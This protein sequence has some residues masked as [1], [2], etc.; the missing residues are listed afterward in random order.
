MSRHTDDDDARPTPATGP[1]RI[2][3]GVPW[4][5]AG[6]R[7]PV[8]LLALTATVAAFWF[9]A[10]VPGTIAG[11][12]LVL[13]YLFVPPVTVFAAG[14][15]AATALLPPG[16]PVGLVAIPV[17]PLVVLLLTTPTGSTGRTGP[18]GPGRLRPGV[19]LVATALALLGV[20]ALA[21]ALTDTLWLAGLALFLAGAACHVSVDLIT[22]FH[23]EDDR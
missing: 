17:V 1:L 8:D 11:G 21:L 6:W 13:A 18:T 23:V 3:G 20:T 12:A 19:V 15:V 9:V 14:I 22:L 16:S 7:S 2:T 4:R 10:D 5:D